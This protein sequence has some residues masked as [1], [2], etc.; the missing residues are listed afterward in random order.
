VSAEKY[1]LL[2]GLYEEAIVSVDDGW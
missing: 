1:Q 2:N